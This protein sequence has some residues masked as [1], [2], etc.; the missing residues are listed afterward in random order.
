MI[1]RRARLLLAALIAASVGL[2]VIP[3]DAFAH[4]VAAGDKGYI[5]SIFGVHVIPFA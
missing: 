2:L 4:G 1:D 3:V 5:Q